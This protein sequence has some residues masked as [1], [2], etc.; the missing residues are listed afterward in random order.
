MKVSKDLREHI[1]SQVNAKAAPA[2]R[3][4]NERIDEEKRKAAEFFA[5]ID[6]LAEPVRRRI[7]AEVEKAK[8][9]YRA[10][11]YRKTLANTIVLPEVEGKNNF[12][13]LGLA[14]LEVRRSDIRDKAERRVREIVVAL[15]L[16]GTAEDL[17]RMLAET[18]FDIPQPKR[19]RSAAK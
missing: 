11:G 5:R 9:E 19:G 1:V 3:A 13:S 8:G 10:T 2:I 18:S 14:P 7:A 16:G 4:I 17:A 12:E 15:E 6:A